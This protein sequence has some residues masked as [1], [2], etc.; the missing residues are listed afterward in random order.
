MLIY[1][2][3][4]KIQLSRAVDPLPICP[5]QVIVPV[6]NHDLDCIGIYR[7]HFVFYDLRWE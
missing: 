5:R 3:L 2:L 4:L 6:Q 1:A 7:C